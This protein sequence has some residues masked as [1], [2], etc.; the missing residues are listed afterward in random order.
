MVRP[1][2]TARHRVN[3]L[4]PL[5]IFLWA[6]GAPFRHVDRLVAHG[7]PDTGQHRSSTTPRSLTGL[8]L[9]SRP[10]HSRSVVVA[11]IWDRACAT[12]AGSA[13]SRW[14][15]SPNGT[16]TLAPAGCCPDRETT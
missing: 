7:Q 10:F 2:T 16:W 6:G 5:P 9:A 12:S 15:T 14:Q 13:R 3:Y 11:R 1:P 8:T 4:F